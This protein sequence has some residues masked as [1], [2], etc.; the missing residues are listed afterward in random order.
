MLHWQGRRSR[1]RSFLTRTQTE[2]PD[3]L[4]GTAQCWR[5][6][7]VAV[8]PQISVR[9]NG[10][11]KKLEPRSPQPTC[12]LAGRT[13]GAEYLRDC[14]PVSVIINLSL[15]AKVS[16]GI[17][18]F[19]KEETRHAHPH[20]REGLC[21]RGRPRGSFELNEDIEFAPAMRTMPARLDMILRR[22]SAAA[23][24]P[25]SARG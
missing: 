7:D 9:V 12:C 13:M 15:Q 8:I 11:M 10:S 18:F 1:A 2:E 14:C 3:L 4:P 17:G 21:K 6:R 16:G 23:C 22:P 5:P 24:R 19:N 20:A 25:K